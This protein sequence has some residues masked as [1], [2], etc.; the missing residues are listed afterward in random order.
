VTDGDP[1]LRLD[2]REDALARLGV[3]QEVG[4]LAGD[5]EVDLRQRLLDLVDHHAEEP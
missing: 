2:E 3:F 5:A 4:V 1:V